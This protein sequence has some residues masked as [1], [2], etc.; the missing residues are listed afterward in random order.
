[1]F[2][3]NQYKNHFNLFMFPFD[4]RR[5]QAEG[6]PVSFML[7]AQEARLTAVKQVAPTTRWNLKVIE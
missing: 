2:A 1:M 5:W 3:H 6:H 7:K 4:F